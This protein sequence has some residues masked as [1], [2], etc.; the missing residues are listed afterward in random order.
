[1]GDGPAPEQGQQRGFQ[2]A[3]Q[4]QHQGQTHHHFHDLRPQRRLGGPMELRPVQMEH[5]KQA[6]GAEQDLPPVFHALLIIFQV[7]IG[8]EVVEVDEGHEGRRSGDKQAVE[9]IQG[10]RIFLHVLK[11]RVQGE[12]QHQPQHEGH[13]H[14][15]GGVHPQIHPGNG[16]QAHQ[17]PQHDPQGT[18]FEVPGRGAQGGERIL[19]VAA[20]EG[21]P[22]G[23]GPGGFH[24][25]ET[26]V[27]H[28]GP[29]D[30]E[31]QL[32]K[33]VHD[34]AGKAHGHH[35]VAAFFV[36]APEND[37]GRGQ[38]DHL[39]P[40]LRDALHERIQHRITDALQKIKHF[41]RNISSCR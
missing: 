13:A 11:Q 34:D 22:R 24:N 9:D 32:E 25:G 19:G 12:H 6:D 39:A 23:G 5:Q 20:G 27:L 18:V 35:I 31:P 28:P 4:D 38:K 7:Q 33:L 3:F 14:I 21:V 40:Q 29:G 36:H 41:Q 26:G 37:D 16:G 1:M 15:P 30:A 8:G 10:F 2:G 17:H